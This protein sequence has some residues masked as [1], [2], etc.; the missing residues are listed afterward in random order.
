[1][2]TLFT[3]NVLLFKLSYFK[4]YGSDID[5]NYLKWSEYIHQIIVMSH[6]PK[7]NVI[8]ESYCKWLK[9]FMFLKWY[10]RLVILCLHTFFINNCISLKLSMFMI[11]YKVHFV[12]V[13]LNLTYNTLIK[14]KALRK[15]SLHEKTAASVLLKLFISSNERCH[16]TD[17]PWH[18]Y[19]VYNILSL[20]ISLIYIIKSNNR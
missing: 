3:I 2:K 6:N 4:M 19:I 12:M 7:M 15:H 5:K 11:G 10:F 13:H 17:A 14:R 20:I 1:M 16:T 9:C 18:V 8:K